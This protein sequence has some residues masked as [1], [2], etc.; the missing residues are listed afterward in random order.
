MK[1]HGWGGDTTIHIKNL[2]NTIV[3]GIQNSELL[4]PSYLEDLFTTK[5]IEERNTNFVKSPQ[6]KT[7]TFGVKSVTFRN[8][9][10][11]FK[12]NVAF[13]EKHVL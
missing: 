9:R 3:R 1:R 12:E 11:D 6:M 2:Q 5:Q 13:F 10:E 8:S 4:N 7:H